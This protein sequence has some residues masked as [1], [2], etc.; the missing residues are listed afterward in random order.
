MISRRIRREVV[1]F[2]AKVLGREARV[3]AVNEANDR[4]G[5]EFCSLNSAITE[6][7]RQLSTSPSPKETVRLMR[8]LSKNF[9]ACALVVQKWAD[10][11]ARLNSVADAGVR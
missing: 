11:L 6:I 7:Y 10:E 2:A 8:E 9:A 4:F 3:K 5:Q 1:K